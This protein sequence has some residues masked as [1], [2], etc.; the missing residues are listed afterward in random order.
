MKRREEDQI[1]KEDEVIVSIMKA[2]VYAFII[3]FLITTVM[4]IYSTGAIAFYLMIAYYSVMS[5]G[6]QLSSTR[7]LTAHYYFMLMKYILAPMAASYGFLIVFAILLAK[8]H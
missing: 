4:S 2:I 1:T 3:P 5:L 6:Y 7:Q 8:F